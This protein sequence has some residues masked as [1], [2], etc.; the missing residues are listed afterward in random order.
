M[1]VLGEEWRRTYYTRNIQIDFRAVRIKSIELPFSSISCSDIYATTSGTAKQITL[2]AFDPDTGDTL[3]F[4]IVNGPQQ[5]TLTSIDHREKL[6]TLLTTGS[7]VPILS[8][9]AEHSK[10]RFISIL[11]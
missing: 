2:L 4:T 6:L 7:V 3:T 10:S 11:S 1:I 9:S 8:P 5:G